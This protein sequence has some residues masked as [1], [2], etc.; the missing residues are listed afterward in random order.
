MVCSSAIRDKTGGK[1]VVDSGASMHMLEQERRE[2]C[3][4]G[5]HE[6]I[7]ESSQGDGLSTGS[8]CPGYIYRSNII[9]AGCRNS[10]GVRASTSNE[11]E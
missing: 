3:R 5:N 7:E 10:N 2:L 6:D 1:C 8:S 4:I 11:Y 9:V